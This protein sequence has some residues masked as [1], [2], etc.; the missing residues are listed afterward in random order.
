MTWWVRICDMIDVIQQ[1]IAF[2]T[3][4]FVPTH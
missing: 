1:C 2:F 3:G 4:N